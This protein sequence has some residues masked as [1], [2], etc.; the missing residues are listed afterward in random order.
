MTEM[1]NDFSQG[2]MSRR[3]LLLGAAMSGAL[4]AF[5]KDTAEDA[6]AADTKSGNPEKLKICIFSKHLQ[7]ASISD[8]AAIARDIGFDGVDITVRVGGHVSPERVE[9]DLPAAVEAVHRAGLTVPMITTDIMSVQ[10]PHADAIMKTANELGIR[11]Y[12]WGFVTYP[13]DEGIAERLVQLRPQ[14]KALAALNQE[15]QICGMYHTHSG[16]GLVGAPI[17][18]LWNL[19]QGLDPR[20][21]GVNY[22]IGHATVEGGYGGWIDSSRLVMNQMRGI[23]LKDFTWQQN[24]GKNTHPDPFDKSLGIQNAWVPHWCPTG[25]GMVNF[26]GFFAIVKAGGTFSGPVQLHFE[27]PLGGAENGKK[28]LTIPKQEVINAMRRD[29][30]F[31]RKAM[32]EKELI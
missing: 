13:A 20:W 7:W 3:T 2:V 9:T 22:D 15:H 29:L 14:M 17:W 21:I 26:S 11:N 5:A 32:S 12:R 27:Y 30:T 31:A 6:A 18:D 8:A 16:P 19:F 4:H 23:A 28:T 1:I 10:T 24:K 25:E